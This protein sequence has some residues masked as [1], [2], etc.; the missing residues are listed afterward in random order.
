MKHFVR[1]LVLA[2]TLVTGLM[3]V[4]GQTV[5]V[6]LTPKVAAL[7]ATAINYLND[8]FRYFNV[9]FVVNGAGGE[10]LD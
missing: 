1:I 8:P 4:S 9:Q 2:V 3:T 5:Q 10:G 7:P 6:L